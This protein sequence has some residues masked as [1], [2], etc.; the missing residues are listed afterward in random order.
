MHEEKVE[1][2]SLTE[3]MLVNTPNP[4]A[5]SF[6]FLEGTKKIYFFQVLVM[7]VLKYLL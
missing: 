1:W 2:F 6:S 5:N 7:F 3:N 4:I